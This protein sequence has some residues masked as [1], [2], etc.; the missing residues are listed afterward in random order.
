MI[1]FLANW[2]YFVAPSSKCKMNPSSAEFKEAYI[3]SITGQAGE[4]GMWS[5]TPCIVRVSMYV[6]Q[7]HLFLSYS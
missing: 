5:H 1:H 4:L 3:I 6:F 7:L 2:L